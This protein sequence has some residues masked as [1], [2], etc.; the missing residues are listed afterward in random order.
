MW[1]SGTL[2]MVASSTTISCGAAGASSAS[3]AR[4]RPAAA[5]PG[6]AARAVS[7][8]ISDM[9][10]SPK[11][12]VVG[13]WHGDVLAGARADARR[14][15]SHGGGWLGQC[16]GERL[17]GAV[18]DS[19]VAVDGAVP[20]GA[21]HGRLAGQEAVQGAGGHGDDRVAVRCRPAADGERAGVGAEV[22]DLRPDPELPRLPGGPRGP[23]APGP[24]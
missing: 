19:G 2:T 16:C 6:A 9:T 13:R 3:P 8:R 14:G 22:E 7:D 10:G 4:G 1:G 24:A 17:Q 21:G 15:A 23:A 11:C 5:P 12:L 20:D 18:G